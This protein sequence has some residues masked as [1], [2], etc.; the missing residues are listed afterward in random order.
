[1]LSINQ[2]TQVLHIGKPRLYR[3][4]KKCEISPIPDGH[5]KILTED[6][7]EILKEVIASSYSKVVST[8]T[9]TSDELG[10]S[11]VQTGDEL[12]T[13]SVQTSNEPDQTS[14]NKTTHEPYRELLKSKDEQIQHLQKIIELEQQERKEKDQRH[15]EVLKEFNQSTERFQAMLMQL[16]TKNN[17]LSQKLL[18]AP[19]GKE[20]VTV[21]REAF[22]DVEREVVDNSQNVLPVRE[23]PLQPQS[24]FFTPAIWAAAAVILTISIVEL[25]GFSVSSL[26][27]DLLA[28]R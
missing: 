10:T 16:Q 25:G 24:R 12:G 5:R 8:N 4:M 26:V 27:R 14:N 22:K 9:K 6:Q 21:S 28:L 15:D 1:M 17:E 13:S 3:L 19:K 2:A 11:S 7:I 18:E 23:Q 20:E